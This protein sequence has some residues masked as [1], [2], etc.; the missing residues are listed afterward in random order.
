ML[1][2]ATIIL[3]LSNKPFAEYI[4]INTKFIGRANLALFVR[5]VRVCEVL[6]ASETLRQ[7]SLEQATR[8]KKSP[9]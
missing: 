5:H 2:W 3:F 9:K 8:G 1:I 6:H 4:C 7:E